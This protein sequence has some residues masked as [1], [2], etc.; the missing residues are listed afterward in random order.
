MGGQPGKSGAPSGID[1][2]VTVLSPRHPTFVANVLEPLARRWEAGAPSSELSVELYGVLHPWALAFAASLSRSLPAHVDRNEVQSQAL[3]LTWKA[4]Q[5]VDWRRYQAWPAYLEIRVGR[6]RIEAARSDDWL[7]RGERVR[8]RRFQDELARRE[9]LEHRTLSESER[10]V[11][12]CAVAPSSTRV[13]WSKE[14]LA[15]RHPSTVGEV[16]DTLGEATTEDM[17]EA[18]ELAHIRNRCVAEWLGIVATQNQGLATDLSRWTSSSDD[19]ARGLPAR[20]AHRLEP[21]KPLLLA[22]LGEA[23]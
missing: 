18:N 3:G 20:L 2:R 19:A 11:V 8:R 17:V 10:R 9:Q 16:P 1:R 12:A 13:D 21:Y 22:L 6:A 23:A 15:A 14:I 7:S 4:C 5:N